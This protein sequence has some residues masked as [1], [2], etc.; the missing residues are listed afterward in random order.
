MLGLFF[1][2]KGAKENV[3]LVKE[4]LTEFGCPVLQVQI[5]TIDGNVL[6]S[7][8]IE[9]SGTRPAALVRAEGIIQELGELD[10]LLLRR[11]I[12]I[13][14]SWNMGAANGHQDLDALGLAVRDISLD[15]AASTEQLGFLA[16]LIGVDLSGAVGTEV[17][18]GITIAVLGRV[19]DEGNSGIVDTRV[20]NITQ[21][22]T[23]SLTL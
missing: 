21:E 11:H 22:T 10:A 3:V 5:E 19:V 15:E 2:V 17:A 14:C 20:A 8:L 6:A 23:T 16:V 4:S 7:A 13:T 1:S 18:P 9:G 12:V